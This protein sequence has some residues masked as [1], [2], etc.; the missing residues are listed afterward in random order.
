MRLILPAILLFSAAQADQSSF[1]HLQGGASADKPNFV[2]IFADDLGYGDLSCYGSKTIATP[3]LDKLAAEGA[4]FTQFYSCAP[5][6]TPS[7]AGLLTGR[8]QVRSG[9]VRVLFPKDKV[10]IEEGE[11]T[12]AEALKKQGYATGMVGKWHLG[13]QPEHLPTKHGFDSY[14]GIPYS[15][16]M[17]PTPLYRNEEQIEEPAVQATLTKRYAEE[18]VRFVKASKGKPF[19]LYFAHTMPHVPLAVSDAFKGK[20]KGGLY[21]DVV[22]ELDWSVGEVMKALKDAGVE[23]NTLVFFTSDNGPWLVKK[24]HGGSAG[25]LRNGKGTP[26]EGGIREPA[27]AWWPGKIPEGR[28]V[29]EPAITLDVF[30]TF[31]ALAGGKLDDRPYD[32]KD[33]WPV[34]SGKGSVGDRELVCY[35]NGTLR[36]FRSG[37]WKFHVPQGKD[38]KGELYDLEADIAETKNLA[39]EKP[40]LARQLHERVLALQ[41]E[42][43]KGARAKK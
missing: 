3:N 17:K 28:T 29:T 23:Q 2:L 4:R 33:L 11:V 19:F 5:N 1:A 12:L 10:G 7:R 43:L 25:P 31:A 20:S 15:N 30:P 35:H 38:G 37:R 24:E 26:Y 16:D 42:H 34:L 6:C 18:A 39:E 14:L 27:I 22:E 41:A 13:C 40:D 8:Y 32:G 36:S 9:L 21:G